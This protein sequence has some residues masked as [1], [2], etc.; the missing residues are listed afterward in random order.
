[1]NQK[2]KPS[3]AIPA[4]DLALQSLMSS[5]VDGMIS[6]DPV[7]GQIRSRTTGHAGPTRNVPGPQPVDHDLTHFE[8]EYAIH[9]DHIRATDVDVF[10]TAIWEVAEKYAE[11]MGTAF[12]QTMRDVTEAVGN[13]IDAGGQPFTWDLFLDGLEKMEIA[14]D[15][16][17]QPK[18]QVLINPDTWRLLQAVER[19][20]EH[21][22]RLE[23]IMQR[24]R[25]EWNAQQRPRRLPRQG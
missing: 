15:E 17:G 3:L 8:A 23:D 11:A 24:K 10:V 22:R 20:P 9:V 2:V 1:M 4:Y 25:G 12:F 7:L 6:V 16:N 13:A 5:I 18:V 14:F 21:D 19:T